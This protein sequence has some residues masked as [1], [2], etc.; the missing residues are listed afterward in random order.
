VAA[1]WWYASERR[2]QPWFLP[3]LPERPIVVNA[4]LES[5][6]ISGLVGL[7]AAEAEFQGGQGG[8][9]A[10]L[11]GFSRLGE[12]QSPLCWLPEQ[13]RTTLGLTPGDWIRLA[14]HRLQIAGFFDGVSFA[15]LRHLSGEPL[16][17]AQL[18]APGQG[19]AA[20]SGRGA[21]ELQE[22]AIDFLDPI[23]LAIVPAWMTE[24]LGG[25]LTSLMVRPAGIDR[26]PTAEQAAEL[27]AVASALAR[28]SAFGIYVSDGRGSTSGGGILAINAAE[29]S[30]PQDLG[31]VLVPMLI[32]GVIVLN[33]MLGAVAERT[34][35][36]HV[37]TSVGLSPAHVGML[38]LAEAAALGTLGVVF[39]YIFGQG[40]ATVLSWTH[41]LPGVD[42]NYSSMSAIITMGLVLGLVMISAL[43]PAR[44]ATRLAAPSLQRDWK[45][46]KPVGDTLA[47]DLPFTVNET[48]ARGVCAYLAEYLLAT[49]HAGTGRFTAD[50]LQGIVQPTTQGDV[51]GLDARIWLAPYDLGVIQT[52]HLTI[53][54]SDQPGGGGVF[55]VHVRLEREAGNPGTWRRLNRAFLVEIR[56]QF[57]LW[58]AVDPAHVAEYVA[59]SEE[60]FGRPSGGGTESGESG[61]PPGSGGI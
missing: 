40:L 45:L 6:P 7:E 23:S 26:T 51:R 32:A 60:L 59:R 8:I 27:Q 41:L 15:K 58:R 56:K 46:P 48:A 1:R 38:F 14:G 29:A 17:P 16:A 21:Q 43:W 50:N 49:S 9:E 33:T 54:P 5:Y 52:M 42:L 4:A 30:R 25:R 57:L 39:G 10:L 3:V 28:R 36:I 11:P 34:R 2:E 18:N 61:T 31:T 55:D 13:A 53:H 12:G 44:S 47:V 24:A 20:G 22:G 19:V 35:E 37:Y